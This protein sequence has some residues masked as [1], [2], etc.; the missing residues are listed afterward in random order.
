MTIITSTNL[1]YYCT[2]VDAVG[3]KTGDI[4][5]VVVSYNN[6]CTVKVGVPI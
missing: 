2:K 5:M 1:C 3:V 4:E 6:T